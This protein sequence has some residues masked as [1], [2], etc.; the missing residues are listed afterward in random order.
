M[1]TWN[2][3]CKVLHENGSDTD[4]NLV[5]WHGFPQFGENVEISGFAN[6]NA[7]KHS[8]NLQI[9]KIDGGLHTFQSV[10]DP[11]LNSFSVQKSQL[12]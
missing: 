9:Y 10:F 2:L 3:N 8:S 1:V 7:S 4:D 5:I 11:S 6:N 12:W